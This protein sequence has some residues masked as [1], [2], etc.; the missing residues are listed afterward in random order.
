MRHNPYSSLIQ[1]TID[2]FWIAVGLGTLI[3]VVALI[4]HAITGGR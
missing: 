1:K 4:T 3:T 2:C